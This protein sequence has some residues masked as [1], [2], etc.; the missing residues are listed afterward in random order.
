MT[1]RLF[2]RKLTWHWQRSARGLGQNITLQELQGYAWSQ[3]DFADAS[4]GCPDSN[5]VYAQVVTPGYQFQ[6][7]Y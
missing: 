7:T 1:P 2:P 6:L 4:L 5:Q 3:Q